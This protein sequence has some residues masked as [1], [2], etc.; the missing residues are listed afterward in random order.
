MKKKNKNNKYWVCA[1][2]LE[3]D[4]PFV[5]S[6]SKKKKSR[7]ITDF[8]K[9]TPGWVVYICKIGYIPFIKIRYNKKNKIGE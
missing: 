6:K 5:T 4:K 7:F 2:N 3:L 9:T 1:E 8:Y